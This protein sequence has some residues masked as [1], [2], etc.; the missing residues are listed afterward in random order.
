MSSVL[1]AAVATLAGGAPGGPTRSDLVAYWNFSSYTANASTSQ[2]GVLGSISP[3]LGAGALSIGGTPTMAYNTVTS[4][5]ANGTVGGFGGTTV[6]GLAGEVAS[7]AL[8]VVGNTGGAGTVSTNG[9]WVQFQIDMSNRQDLQMSFAT[10][11]TSTGFDNNQI[12]WSTDGASFTNFGAAWSGRPTT[13]FSVERD[14]TTVTALNNMSNVFLRI[15]FNGA[16]GASGN[17]RIDNVQFNANPLVIPLPPAA[18]AGLSTMACVFVFGAMRR[19][20]N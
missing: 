13:F 5:T 14:L 16:T 17:N 2:L 9:G 6:N 19:R 12:S 20:R 1:L 10:R 4:G 3:S 15:T 18:W 11:G 7:G 8:T